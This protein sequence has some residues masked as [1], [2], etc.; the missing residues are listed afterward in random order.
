ML[1]W[2]SISL[3]TRGYPVNIPTHRQTPEE[4]IEEIENDPLT[5]LI[6]RLL[7]H[8]SAVRQYIVHHYKCISDMIH[9]AYIMI[10]SRL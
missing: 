6:W 10:Q 1:D 3:S 7:D 5:L 2:N 9:H 8:V 4:L